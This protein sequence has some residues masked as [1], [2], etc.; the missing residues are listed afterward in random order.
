MQD[1][2]AF[3]ATGLTKRQ[4]QVLVYTADGFSTRETAEE[5]KLSPET[6][7]AHR[8]SI[9]SKL[10]VRNMTQAVA[11]AVYSGWLGKREENGS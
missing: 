6:I 7:K 1:P 4:F 2:E 11:Y 10:G 5:L 8:R 3:Q 9:L